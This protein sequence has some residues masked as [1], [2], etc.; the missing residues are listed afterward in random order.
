MQPAILTFM[1]EAM[2]QL[3]FLD[4]VRAYGHD[5]ITH[6][7]AERYADDRRSRT[8]AVMRP[9]TPGRSASELQWDRILVTS[10]RAAI[11]VG[12]RAGSR[13]GGGVGLFIEWSSAD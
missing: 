11:G 13:L 2:P 1:S 4:R 9:A 3:L 7:E 5:H 8:R 12:V 6:V 10:D